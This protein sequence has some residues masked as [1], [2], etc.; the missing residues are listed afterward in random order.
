MTIFLEDILDKFE[1]R[2]K[3]ITKA[4]GYSNAVD[5]VVL[6]ATLTP[7]SGDD[8]PHLNFWSDGFD[9][10]KDDYGRDAHLVRVYVEGR[11]FTRDEPFVTVAGRLALDIHTALHR[12]TAAP[13]FSDALD[14]DLGGTVGDLQ[15]ASGDFYIGEGGEPFCAVL[16]SYIAKTYTAF[17]DYSVHGPDV[18]MS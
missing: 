15:L 8:M 5:G 1:E 4:N 14:L 10:A 9:T 6:R 2:L 11:A 18:G 16:M 17:G 12:T 7:P 3:A 13:K